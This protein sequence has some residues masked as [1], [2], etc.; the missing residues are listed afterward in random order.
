[1]TPTQIGS[2]IAGAFQP[3]GLFSSGGTVSNILN[4]P[5]TH[6]ALGKRGYDLIRDASDQFVTLG[7][8][9]QDDA[10][11]IATQIQLES[12]FQPYTV[13]TGSGGKITLDETG[14]SIDTGTGKGVSDA[15]LGRARTR[16]DQPS[17]GLGVM[18][19][20]ANA[21]GS[22][23]SNLLSSDPLMSP[24]LMDTGNFLLSQ[25]QDSF[26]TQP[27]LSA[28]VQNASQ[29][30]LNRGTS[31]LRQT[32]TGLARQ[33][34]AARQ[35][36]GLGSTFMNY[37]DPRI[38]SPEQRE[39]D[40]YNR[41]RATQEP[42]EE[43]QR[44]ALEERLANQGRLGVRTS[45]FGGTSEQM[46]LAKAQE[47]AKNQAM[48]MSM[49]Q[50]QQEQAQQAALGAQYAGLG[51]SMYGQQQ[52]MEASQQQQALQALT[53]GSSIAAQNQA[54]QNAQQQI[55]L[56]ALSGGS[57]IAAQEEAIRNMQQQRALQSF[58]V[59]QGLFAG[60]KGLQQAQQQMATNAL[61]AAYIPEAQTLN[62]LQQGLAAAQLQQ[63]EQMFG[64]G[65]F[66]ETAMSGREANIA[67]QVAR[68][69]MLGAAGT[70]LFG[71]VISGL[72]V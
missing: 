22:A 33:E 2:A 38:T 34:L 44:L 67:A 1:M 32:P 62:A 6:L 65:L 58:Q 50:S 30:L 37:A 59:G 11:D 14:T 15:L 29:E 12:E 49:Q 21:A 60:R 26:N 57:N 42:E 39:Q 18:A 64:T 56:Q 47:E 52:A 46:A 31:Q 16:L 55:A 4:S 61:A 36:L 20:W 41:I 9:A 66:A 69:N 48:L 13:T 53:G 7:A 68:A 24:G 28:N 5:L 8:T 23:G 43:R 63:Q 71:A 54:L 19:D 35:A 70:S 10:D 51:S 72:G 27:V 3:G 45:M 17:A 25:G 40:V